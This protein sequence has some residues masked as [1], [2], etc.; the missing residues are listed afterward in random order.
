MLFKPNLKKSPSPSVL[1]IERI[2]MQNVESVQKA[3]TP[4]E[5]LADHPRFL[6]Q[7]ISTSYK[8]LAQEIVQNV[9]ATAD[10]ER[11]LDALLTAKL[12][13]IQAITHASYHIAATSKETK[14]AQK[15]A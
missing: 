5:K 1:L 11:A 3:F 7:S 4:V 14:D 2:P 6:M 12:M 8:D 10:R 15:K 9:P 13:T